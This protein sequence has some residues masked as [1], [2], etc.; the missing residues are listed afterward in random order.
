MIQT[1]NAVGAQRREKENPTEIKEDSMKNVAPDE[2][3]ER[4][5]D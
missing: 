3:L 2:I 5:G 1:I 4:W